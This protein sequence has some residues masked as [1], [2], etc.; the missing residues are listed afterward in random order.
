MFASMSI[1]PAVKDLTSVTPEQRAEA[2]RAFAKLMTRLLTEKCVVEARE[3]VKYEGE[4][5]LG[6]AFNLFGQVAAR[7]MFSNPS[8]AAALGDLEKL[9]DF[10]ALMKTLTEQP[11]ASEEKKK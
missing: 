6:N 4:S 7:D 8:V 1:H 11:S 3:A 10:K 9:L 5:A 2:N